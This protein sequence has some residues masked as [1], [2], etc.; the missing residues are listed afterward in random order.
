MCFASGP[1]L[2]WQ[3]SPVHAHERGKAGPSGFLRTR[4]V[5]IETASMH[6]SRERYRGCRRRLGR[7][8][9]GMGLQVPHEMIDK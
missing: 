9:S 7:G 8:D 2:R 5:R 3:A 6:F 1:N 4:P